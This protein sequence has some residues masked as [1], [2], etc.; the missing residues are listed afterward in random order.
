[1]PS[2]V[3]SYLIWQLKQVL[4]RRLFLLI[5]YSYWS[6]PQQFDKILLLIYKTLWILWS[7]VISACHIFYFML[8]FLLNVICNLGHYTHT[9]TYLGWLAQILMKFVYSFLCEL[10]LKI[11]R[12]N[13]HIYTHTH[14]PWLT[15]SNPKRKRPN[16]DQCFKLI[17]IHKIRTTSV[18]VRAQR[19]V[20]A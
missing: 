19:L 17:L 16:Y 20:C 10:F 8:V 6:C 1:M 13:V 7:F 18:H 9:H 2:P 15:S 14:L 4:W 11:Q 3:F 5:K 12:E